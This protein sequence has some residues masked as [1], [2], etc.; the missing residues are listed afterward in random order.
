VSVRQIDQLREKMAIDD[1][2][3]ALRAVG[4]EPAAAELDAMRQDGVTLETNDRD[5]DLRARLVT[6]DPDVAKKYDMMEESE[7]WEGRNEGP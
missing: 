5:G 6:T 2:I 4:D 7:L 1:L 3:S